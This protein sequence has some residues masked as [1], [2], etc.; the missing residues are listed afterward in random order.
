[1]LSHALCMTIVIAI[2]TVYHYGSSTMFINASRLVF[3]IISL[4]CMGGITIALLAM[5]ISC[6]A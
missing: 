2:G 6:I 4:H 5:L 3:C 1:M